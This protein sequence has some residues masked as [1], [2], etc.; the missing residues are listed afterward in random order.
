MQSVR[1]FVGVTATLLALVAVSCS[2]PAGDA[3]APGAPAAAGEEQSAPA[4]RYAGREVSVGDVDTWIKDKLFDNA[5]GNRNA[6]RLYEIRKRALEQ[7][8]AEQAL[9]TA[10][11]QA[12]KE[13]EALLREEIEKRTTVTDDEVKAF[14]EQNKARYGD[15]EFAK[16]EESIRRQLQ[17]QKRLA[18]VEE[19]LGGLRASAGYESLLEPPRFE[20]TGDGPSKGPDDAPITLVEFSDYQ[21]PFC[22][23][24]EPIVAQVL[25]RYPTQVRLVYRH[26]PLDNI[27]PLA[28]A[29]SEAALCAGDQDRFWDYH[30]ILF[31]ET[32]KLEPH[33]FVKYAN[34]LGLDLEAFEA[35]VAEKRHAAEVQ[36]DVEAGEKIGVAGTPSFYANG[37]PITGARGVE[38]F[39]AVIDEEL[40]R[41][42]LPVPPA[43]QPAAAQV[44]PRAAIPPAA[45]AAAAKASETEAPV[46]PKPAAPA[47]KPAAPA[48]EAP[49]GN[50]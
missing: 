34:Q 18:A 42:G 28:R 2:P 22:K 47:A 38:Q 19:Y 16:L 40:E 33:L 9:E 8:A 25:E 49:A 48:P 41:L 10:A 7:M 45:A 1:R 14:Y 21:C 32:P 11:A 29:A 27:H 13:R 23:N 35:C 50:P 4:G 26:F 17:Q 20:I 24:A 31:R 30:A 39:A 43:P 5:T 36:A 6:S 12:G 3:P 37:R 15:R 44:A 46:A